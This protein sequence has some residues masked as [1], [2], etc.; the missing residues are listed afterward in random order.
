MSR[1]WFIAFACTVLIVV[2]VWVW[3]SSS[4]PVPID[5]DLSVA[6][7]EYPATVEPVDTSESIPPAMES[8]PAPTSD[9]AGVS[10]VVLD[11]KTGAPIPRY[12]LVYLKAPP[13]G[14]AQ[15]TGI[16]RS[17][18]PE[19]GLFNTEDSLKWNRIES[20]DGRFTLDTIPAGKSF[21]LAARVDGYDGA[22]ISVAAIDG[23]TIHDGVV[24]SLNPV[25]GI[26]GL[27]TSA[28]G[29]PVS[30]AAIHLGDSATGRMVARSDAAGSFRI[31]SLD[32]TTTALFA[33][34]TDY[35]PTV[36]DV[37]QQPG[38][39]IDVRIVLGEGG[40]IAGS[41]LSG[42]SPAPDVQVSVTGGSSFN[43]AVWTDAQ[44]AFSMLGIPDGEYEIQVNPP[45]V[46]GA[47]RWMLRRLAVVE[48]G[49]ETRVE[50]QFP[51]TLNSVQGMITIQGE[52]V[53]NGIVKA[54]MVS[55]LG[56][57][58]TGVGVDAEGRYTLENL[59]DGQLWLDVIVEDAAGL[60]RSCQVE[61]NLAGGENRV[62]DIRFDGGGSLQI[63]V[64]DVPAGGEVS[65]LLLTG[66]TK[67]PLGVIELDPAFKQRVTLSRPLRADE[68][69]TLSGI[70]PDDYVLAVIQ[71]AMDSA[72]PVVTVLQSESADVSSDA[73]SELSISL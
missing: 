44:G 28:D 67:V 14:P 33:D 65:L 11:A 57:V 1:N 68:T 49:L 55:E 29:K 64:S 43:N 15:W 69:I 20:P 18:G 30:G 7:D 61:V 60:Q 3:R 19:G 22:H 58:V 39:V 41:V 53:A 70:E 24:L 71:V 52:A 48:K 34:H 36:I 73:P 42:S 25:S 66:T 10:G 50:I 46:T 51:E 5:T 63:V 12:E 9:L 6:S 45:G 21:A 59:P 17:S 37:T 4:A 47:S 62:E 8:E 54:E 72:G 23:G 16:L 27:V 13:A 32:D 56:D 35:L 26:Q 40:S 38:E 2:A 31:T